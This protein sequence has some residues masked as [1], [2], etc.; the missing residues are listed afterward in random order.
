[1]WRYDNVGGLAEHVTCHLAYVVFWYAF[2][3]FFFALFFGSCQVCTSGPI[4]TI[5]TSYDAF[6]PKDVPVGVSFVVLSNFG[7]KIPKK[8]ISGE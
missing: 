3:E 8:P 4:L 2:L 5:Y 7:V 6:T 1:M